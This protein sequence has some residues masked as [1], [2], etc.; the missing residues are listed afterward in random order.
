MQ[1]SIY[2][3]RSDAMLGQDGHTDIMTHGE[4]NK[5]LIQKWALNLN[6]LR[7]RGAWPNLRIEW[8]IAIQPLRGLHETRWFD[9]KLEN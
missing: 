2:I 7:R 5:V 9:A 4:D 6:R 8:V 1:L 3:L